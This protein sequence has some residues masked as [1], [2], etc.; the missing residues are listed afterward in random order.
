MAHNHATGLTFVGEFTDDPQFNQMS[1]ETLNN[2]LATEI[3]EIRDTQTR[4]RAETSL[5]VC[6][7]LFGVLNT[8]KGNSSQQSSAKTSHSTGKTGKK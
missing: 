4:Q 3:R 6:Q 8:S 2:T 7:S 1:R 5:T